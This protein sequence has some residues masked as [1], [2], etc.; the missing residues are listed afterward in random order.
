MP[1]HTLRVT[2][3]AIIIGARGRGWGLLSVGRGVELAE[4]GERGDELVG[5]GPVLWES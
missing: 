1:S 5:P 3:A 4:Q 2:S